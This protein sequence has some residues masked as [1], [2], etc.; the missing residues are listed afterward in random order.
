MMTQVCKAIDLRVEGLVD[1]NQ[2]DHPNPHFSWRLGQHPEMAEL[3]IPLFYQIR[4]APIDGSGK[5]L[6]EAQVSDWIEWNRRPAVRYPGCRLLP[7][8]A[9]AWQVR[10]SD[11]ANAQGEWSARHRFATGL[12]GEVWPAPWIGNGQSLTRGQTAPARY[13]R[14]QFDL[15]SQ[16]VGARLFLCALGL[17]EPWLNGRPVTSDLFLPGWPDYRR[18][19]YY[20]AYD[21]TSLLQLGANGWG[22]ILGDG[23]YSGTLLPGFQFG[24]EP[25]FSAFIDLLQADGSRSILSPRLCW[26]WTN[27]GPVTMQSIYHGECYD[28]RKELGDWNHPRAPTRASWKPASVFASDYGLPL[29]FACTARV[30]EPVRRQEWRLPETIRRTAK[31]SHIIDFGQ[32]V[33]GWVRLKVRAAAGQTVRLRF[34]EMLDADGSLYLA[35]LRRAKANATYTAKGSG[36]E[37]WEPR[38]TYF[39][40]R[41]VELTGLEELLPDA[42]TAVV[43]HVNVPIS[44]AFDCSDPLLNKL[45]SNTLWS[46]KGNF[47]E[48]P[49]DCPQRDERLGWTGDAQ[50]FASTALYSMQAANFF[51]QWLTALR[52]GVRDGPGGGAPDVAPF[53]GF[54][55]GNAGWGEAGIIVPWKVWLHTGDSRVL[56]ENLPSIQ[57][58]LEMMALE[59]PA[60]LRMRPMVYGDWLSPGYPLGKAPP[61]DEL[62]ATAYFAH[63]AALAAK[64]AHALGRT[65]LAESN[66][67]LHRQSMDAFQK[68]FILPDGRMVDDV[69]TAY[70]LA[71]AFDLTGPALR[72]KVA[73]QLVRTIAE[74]D[75]HPSTGF[76]GT[77][78]LAPVLTSI[79]RSDLAYQL[80]MQRTFPGWLYP[81]L[82]GA[83]TIWERWDSWDPQKGFHQEGMNSF[84]H[85]AYGSVV[86]WFYETVCGLQPLE[87]APGWQLFRVAPQPG[88]GLS[89]AAARILTPYGEAAS[90]WQI[91][92]EVFRLKVRVPPSTLARVILPN[93]AKTYLVTGGL[94]HFQCPANP[95]TG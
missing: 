28:A 44:G 92:D 33:V 95:F 59:A 31:S 1:A 21:V 11:G 81:I 8:T 35:N 23:W 51:R 16:P 46:L 60:G 90:S 58:Q 45:H 38:M 84:N 71:L 36:L 4:L 64:M 67:A 14:T 12:L 5:E 86:S 76:L 63:A 49:T 10:L 50:V 78:L 55:H 29:P 62:I 68:A 32:N 26:E 22:M 25:L 42:L 9:Y 73:A 34:A 40:F 41:Y 19:V 3:A 13:F 83:T 7:R 82:Q 6:G 56:E 43:I 27:D 89:R 2:I 75:F 72:S 88:G 80:V 39:G 37:E 53:T 47:L 79:G 61:R 48:V 77:S 30:A 91:G 52:D 57:Y 24:Q 66:E 69:Q 74:K 94:H 87:E 85:Y 93:Q 70:L 54:F 20:V 65:A 18:R 17:V 15:P